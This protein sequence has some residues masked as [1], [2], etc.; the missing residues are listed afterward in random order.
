MVTESGLLAAAH[1]VGAYGVTD[2]IKNNKNIQDVLG[3][4]AYEYMDLMKNFDISEI[5]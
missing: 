1:L 4:S 2:A 3:T 5:K